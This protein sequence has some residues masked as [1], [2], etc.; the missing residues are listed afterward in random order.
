MKCKQS[1]KKRNDQDKSRTQWNGKQQATEKTNLEKNANWHHGAFYQI[2]K[3]EIR[4]ILPKHFWEIE[5][6]T[7][8]GFL[9]K[10]SMPISVIKIDG[11]ILD[12]IL[13]IQ[14]QK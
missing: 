8:P 13:G 9:N 12:R 6:R 3:E 10:A 7:L 1:T 5:G 4:P 14:I 11:K 2:L